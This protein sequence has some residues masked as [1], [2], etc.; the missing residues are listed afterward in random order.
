MS[1]YQL[2]RPPRDD[3]ELYQLTKALWGVTIPRGKHCAHHNAP[4]EAF[5]TAFFARE[6]QVLVK[7]SRGLSG[8]TAMMAALGLTQAVVLGTDTNI[9]GGS[10]QQ[11]MNA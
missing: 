5:S 8:K 4:F 9:V 10:E 11:A 2:T 3:D 1:R 7:G 6:P